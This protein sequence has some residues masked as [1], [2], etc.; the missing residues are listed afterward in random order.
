[1]SL[2]YFP[3]LLALL[4]DIPPDSIISRTIFEDDRQKVVLFKFSSGQTLSE[5][6]AS[7]PAVLH[8]LDGTAELTLGSERLSASPGTWVHMP[9]QLPHSVTASTKLAM[10]LVLLKER[11]AK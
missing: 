2:T 6:T 1:M 5:H 9:A 7:L 10:L 11:K 4:P 8:F 3:D